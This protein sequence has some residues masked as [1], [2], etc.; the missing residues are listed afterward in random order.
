VN[1]LEADGLVERSYGLLV[2]DR[3]AV[4]IALTER[5]TEIAGT[6]ASVFGA[7]SARICDALSLTLQPS[8]PD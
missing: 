7:H 4:V 1:Q 6:I 5:G 8:S 3:R 2:E